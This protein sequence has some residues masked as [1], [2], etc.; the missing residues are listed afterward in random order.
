MEIASRRNRFEALVE[1][2]DDAPVPERGD[3]LAIEYMTY[4]HAATIAGNQPLRCAVYP[5]LG[6]STVSRAGYRS[7]F[8]RSFDASRIRE[9]IRFSEGTGRTRRCGVAR[10]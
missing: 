6:I 8:Q 9:N 2:V 7:L 3:R 5:D 4:R 10:P 1:R